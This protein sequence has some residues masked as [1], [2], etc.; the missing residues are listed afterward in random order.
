MLAELLVHAPAVA[1]GVSPACRY[2]L[3]VAATFDASLTALVYEIETVPAV[4]LRDQAPA[5]PALSEQD[6][7]E[8]TAAA[9]RAAAVSAGVRCEI[10]TDRSYAYGIGE[11]LADFAHLRDLTILDRPYPPPTGAR[12]LASA[13]LYDSGRP[14]ILVPASAAEF[15][16][17]TVLVAWDASPAAVRAVHDALPLL[18][19]AETV[20]VVRVGDDGSL[21]PGH[22]GLELCRHLARH[23]VSASFRAVDQ[24]STS[25]GEALVHAA[26]LLSADLLVMGAQIHSRLH[27]ALFGSATRYILETNL[28]VPVLMSH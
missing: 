1:H 5:A 26:G 25:V 6:P 3:G 19:K 20:T 28:R 8:A 12:L 4:A 9:I 14:V 23:G 24:G 13:A 17:A 21:R 11:T 7:T 2:A 27:D 18:K 16:A 10:V 22:S 15:R